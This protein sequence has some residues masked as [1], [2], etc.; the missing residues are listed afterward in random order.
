MFNRYEIPHLHTL[1][2]WLLIL[3]GATEAARGALQLYG[4][5][6]SEHALYSF[7]GSFNNPGPYSG[8]LAMIL[9]LSLYQYLSDKGIVKY[10][11][12]VVGC[13]ILC[14]L[15][16]GMSRSAWL[17]AGVSCVFILMTTRNLY[18]KRLSKG[19]L[20]VV[21]LATLVLLSVAAFRV[22]QLKPAS[23]N[24]RLFM[25]R[26]ECRAIAEKPFAGHGIGSFARAYGDAQ[27]AYFARGD[28]AQWEEEVAGSPEYA[29]NEYLQPAIELGIPATLCILAIIATCFV[30]GIKRKRFG[31]C[32]ALLSLAVFAFSSY[33]MQ[34]PLFVFSLCCLLAGCVVNNKRTVQLTAAALLIVIGIVLAKQPSEPPRRGR[35]L[36]E[37]GHILHRKEQW[38]ASTEVLQEALLHS[39]DPMILNIIG[40][41]YQGEGNYA[42]AEHWYIR[43]T[44]RL[45]G[46]I[47]PYYLLAKLYAEP[48]YR[49]PAKFEQM[50]QIVLTKQ[51]KVMSTAI[52]EMRQELKEMTP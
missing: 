51:P 11:P 13:F 34:F 28:Y 44:H 4:F 50:K 7:T 8:Y 9:P 21:G 15:P 45:P 18:P 23:A 22:Y 48:A 25:W 26:M 47:Y 30:V 32:G 43:S 41:N 40:K 38:K 14:L 37:Q 12:A 6:P 5:L 19:K 35:E 39:C 31:L 2:S 24:G 27:E 1:L 29:F 52:R 16:A 10:I 20:I 42:E 17:A 49:N 46:R 33:P 36:F 3:F